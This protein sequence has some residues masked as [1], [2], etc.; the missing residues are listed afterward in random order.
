MAQRQETEVEGVA[1]FL[2]IALKREQIPFWELI[3]GRVRLDVPLDW[4]SEYTYLLTKAETEVVF[5]YKVWF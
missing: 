5:S 1:T 2:S 4:N 3:A